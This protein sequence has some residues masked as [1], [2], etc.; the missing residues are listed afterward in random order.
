MLSILVV[1]DDAAPG[2]DGLA[3]ASAYNDLQDALV[4][5]AI[6]NSDGNTENDIEQIW[7]A[8]GTYKPSGGGTGRS[9]SFS[10]LDGVTLYGGFAGTESSL[11][12]RDLAA[13]E[14]ILSGDLGITED[15]TDNAYTVV[16]CGENIESAIDGISITGGNANS[17]TVG[18]K[19][20]GGIL[21]LG[22]LTITHCTISEN[23]ASYGGGICNGD[24]LDHSI[25]KVRHSKIFGNSAGMGGGIYNGGGSVLTATDSTL[26]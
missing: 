17:S 1:D 5:A 22:T 3:W 12:E 9:V 7:I 13:H 15:P 14:T 8:E 4:Q 2:G 16:K 25:L 26:L 23:S 24:D 11:S 10:L 21:N 6:F 18:N 20:G 19:S